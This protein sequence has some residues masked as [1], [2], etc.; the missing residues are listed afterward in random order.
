MRLLA[1]DGP[2]LL[3][4]ADGAGRSAACRSPRALDELASL[5][6]RIA[7]AQT[8]PRGGR[9]A[10][11]RRARIASY[12]TAFTPE[13]RAA[14]L[15]D[16]R[17]GPRRPARSRRTKRPGSAMTLL[18]LLRVRA[19]RGPSAQASRPCA[20]SLARPA[21]Q[22][23]SAAQRRSTSRRRV[24]APA[25]PRVGGCAGQPRRH[26]SAPLRDRRLAGIRRRTEAARASR[27]N[28]RRRPSS[29]PS[30]ATKSCSRSRKQRDT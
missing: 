4:E 9:C 11:R 29:K 23:R 2:A 22:Q 27:C 7:V 8:V 26:G 24:A 19:G 10:A 6:H 5:F 15:P 14:R 21:T 13:A 25:A 28:S 17:A 1:G 12:A 20:T 16:L 30:P 18:R 3:A